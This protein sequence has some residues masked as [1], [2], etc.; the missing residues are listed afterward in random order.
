MPS[1]AGR[2]HAD[3]SATAV[4]GIAK[5]AFAEERHARI[6]ALLDERGRVRNTELAMLLGVTEPTIRKD[7]A[8][9]ARQGRLHRT[10]GGALAMRPAIEPDM[11]AR[12]VRNPEVK[13]RIAR[14]CL[15]MISPGDAVYL[16]TGSTV[17]RIAELLVDAIDAGTGPRNV[18][19]LTN[20]MPVAGAIAD[21]SGVRHTVL[22]GTYRPAGECFVGPLTLADL[23][24]FTVNIA[25]LGVTG[26]T[27]QGLTVADLNEAQVKRT[28]ISRARRVVVAMDSSKLGAADFARVCSLDE[29]SAIVTDAPNPYLQQL[30][31]ENDV[32]LVDAEVDA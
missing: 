28:V 10:H 20:A 26:L 27:A 11:P 7:V 24:S 16:D 17:L 23:D 8:D 5:A 30:C 18:N 14:A 2:P 32:E 12:V 3:E 15:A 6:L 4:S 31:Q 29:V 1:G 9:L 19:V 13:T 25:F 21:R 22:G